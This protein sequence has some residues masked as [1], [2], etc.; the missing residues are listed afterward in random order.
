MKRHRAVLMADQVSWVEGDVF[1]YVYGAERLE[2]INTLCTLYPTRINT[3]NF[4]QHQ[5]ALS[6]VE[7]IFSCWGM[8]KLSPEQLASMPALKAVF[9]ASGSVKSFAG[10]MLEKGIVV[11]SAAAANAIPVA[12]FCLAQILLSCKAA[13]RNS[14]QCRQGPWIEKEMPA[15]PG[16]Y[17]VTV[18]LIAIG[19]VTRHLLKLLKP[20]NLRVIAVSDYLTESQAN[21]M[22]IAKLVDIETAFREGFVVSNH[23]PD[24]LGLYK[25][26]NKGHFA[27]MQPGATFLN[28]GRGKQ[29]DEPGLIEVLQA[30]PD[31]TALL[32]VQDPEP[33]VQGSPLYTLPNVTLTSHIAGSK[34]NEVRRMADMMIDDYLAWRDGHPLQNQVRLE[35]FQTKA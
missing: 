24:I 19:A 34:N 10:P 17:G 31:L 32:D 9:Y 1:D 33:P 14:A 35:E 12:E 22:G 16:V 11:C 5:A 4:A 6:E 8:P 3:G 30:R 21:A 29:V 7:V 15:G 27:S 20:F 28:T 26:L 2:K 23:L 25:I 13:Y 18:A